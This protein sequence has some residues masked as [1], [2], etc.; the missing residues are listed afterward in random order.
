MGCA[1]LKE[2]ETEVILALR[3]QL[4]LEKMKAK[5]VEKEWEIE[6]GRIVLLSDPGSGSAIGFESSA[7]KEVRHLLPHMSDNSED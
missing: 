3:L 2:K 6:K 1:D 7:G 4:E 5:R